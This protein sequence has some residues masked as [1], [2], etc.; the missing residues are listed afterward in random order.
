MIGNGFDLHYAL[1]TTYS[2]F[3][4]T[5]DYLMGEASRG[6]RVE[7]VA[8]V[9]RQSGLY[10]CDSAIRIC[11][12][13]YGD[14]F[15]APLNPEAIVKYA[16][17]GLHNMW[18]QYLL[19]V[20]S[21]EIGW[22]DVEREIAKV[23]DKFDYI[24]KNYICSGPPIYLSIPCSDFFSIHL[25]S[26]FSFFYD[27][28]RTERIYYND[29]HEAKW[30]AQIYRDY[31]LEDPRGSQSYSINLEKIV[32]SVYSSLRDF[33]DLLRQYLAWFV[34]TPLQNLNK[35]N[36][37]E[38]DRF[39]M[40]GALKDALVISFNYTN[41]L[42]QLYSSHIPY[43]RLFCSHLHGNTSDAQSIVLGVNADNNDNLPAVDTL[44]IPFK[45]YYQRVLFETDQIYLNQLDYI[46]DCRKT[47]PSISPNLKTSNGPRKLIALYVIGHSLDITDKEII[48]DLF[49]RAEK[50]VVFYHNRN[51]V[52][53][54]I[55]NLVQ[56]YGKEGFDTLRTNKK[57]TFLSISRLSEERIN[58][59]AG[60]SP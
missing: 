49:S 23:I 41:T 5:L 18:A 45:K 57:L 4:S 3:L 20:F 43:S 9:Y 21:E 59:T 26:F 16:T 6:K 38:C 14:S 37:V 32:K 56:I 39:L 54:Y 10:S 35:S 24:F 51:A 53:N 11:C 58:D 60:H 22:I 28:S 52:A 48:Q 36:R 40:G 50:I 8:Q 1:P 15:D 42:E 31:I 55:R 44:F 47:S 27:T 34:E 17:M 29:I 25:L 13:T 46:D 33:T 19:A 12:D 2:A 7:S 30:T